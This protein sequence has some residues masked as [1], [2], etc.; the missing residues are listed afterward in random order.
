MAD[1]E[2][3]KLNIDMFDNRKIKHL[4]KLPEGNNIVLIWV[5]LLTMAGR[6]NAGGMIFLTENIPYT[7]KML[8]DE[9][10]F[11]ENVV[12][13]ALQALSELNMIC[14]DENFISIPGWYEYQSATGLEKIREQNRIRKQNQRKREKDNL[15]EDK[16]RD[17]HVTVTQ[18]SYS[19]SNSLSNSNNIS[20]FNN[21]S[22][23]DTYIYINNIK[24][25]LEVVI[26]W[27]EYKD[28]RG[29][30][31]QYKEKGLKAILKQI[32]NYHTE[33]GTDKVVAVIEDSMANNYMGI[34]WDK[35][36]KIKVIKQIPKQ[37]LPFEPTEEEREM[38]DEE[39]IKMM[40]ESDL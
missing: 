33:Y 27:L 19:Y 31:E 32:V 4:R 23:L 34:C 6:C 11:D 15:I 5:M 9:L 40:Q 21:L 2:W 37:P 8:A 22:N 38:T 29:K 1:V 35:I 26:A 39:W 25:L 7:T 36:E 30:K 10:G 14:T 18:S 17:S 28:S 16:S 13:I 3:V 20:L 24:E 12:K